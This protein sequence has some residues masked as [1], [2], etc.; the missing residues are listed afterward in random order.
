MERET[1]H[2]LLRQFPLS[3]SRRVRFPPILKSRI[4]IYDIK[5]QS[6]TRET[7]VFT[8]YKPIVDDKTIPFS[9]LV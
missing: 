9:P 7:I 4:K 5:L 6:V 3:S 1:T 8:I 2:D